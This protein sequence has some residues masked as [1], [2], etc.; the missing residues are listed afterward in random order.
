MAIN[1][2]SRRSALGLIVLTLLTE[3][4][5]YPYRMQ[6]LIRERGKDAVVNVRQRASLYQ[7]IERLHRDGL[8]SV[9]QTAQQEGRPERTLYAITELGRETARRWTRDMLSRPAQH[10]PEFPAALACIPLLT[11]EDAL[12][13]LHVRL[14]ALTESVRQLHLQTP[15]DAQVPRL[16]LLESEYQMAVLQAERTWVTALIADLKDGHLTWNDAWLRAVLAQTAR[17]PS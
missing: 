4:P 8:I 14:E 5:M 3:E 17:E 15:D 6:Q 12:N 7:S 1:F 2:D 13:Q 9:H 10:Y 16:F 11:P